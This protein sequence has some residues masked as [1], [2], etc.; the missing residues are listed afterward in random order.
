MADEKQD[1]QLSFNPNQ[2]QTKPVEE[3]KPEGQSQPSAETRKPEDSP[4]LPDKYRD[5]SPEQVLEMA[6]NQD[7][8]IGRLG[9]EVGELRDAIQRNLQQ[10]QFRTMGPDLMPQAA[11]QQGQGKFVDELLGDQGE[12]YARKLAKEEALR[13]FVE[14]QQAQTAIVRERYNQELQRVEQESDRIYRRIADEEQIPYE[15][16][17]A[18]CNREFR[19]DLGLAE[20]VYQNP[21]SFSSSAIEEG[22]RNLYRRGR[23]SETK[24]YAKMLKDQGFDPEY[25]SQMRNLRKEQAGAVPQSG[26]AT[27]T[28][29]SQNSPDY[30]KAKRFGW[31]HLVD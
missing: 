1:G 4:V 5:K 15:D 29:N 2:G 26:A 13:A 11:P 10:S 12:V 21:Q 8:V 31:G 20:K 7:K 28:G 23:E 17:A 3:V 30:E 16:V 19:A 27:H 9:R 14:L 24:R 6:L 18:L 25:A 22:V